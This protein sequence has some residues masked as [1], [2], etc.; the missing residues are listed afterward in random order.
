MGSQ[1]ARI[2]VA[3]GAL[4]A[5]GACLT[6]PVVR[7]EPT[8]KTGFAAVVRA[9]AV[10]KV[11]LL[12]MIDN[13]ASMGDKQEYLRAAV[14]D[15]LTRLV[16]PNCVDEADP[17]KV[18]GVSQNH[19][20]CPSG[21]KIEFPPVHDMHIAVVTSSLGPR[22]GD[23]CD[24]AIQGA[25][26][27]SLHNDDQGHLINRVQDGDAPIPTM[28]PSH[29]LA[30]FSKVDS[31]NGK[32]P[33]PGAAPIDDVAQLQRDFQDL[34]AGVGQRGCGVESQLESWYRFLIQPDPYESLATTPDGHATWV[35]V[36]ATILKQRHDFL[37]PDSLVAVVVLTDENDS[38]IDVRANNGS[39]FKFL[40]GA[41]APPRG[42]SPCDVNPGDP[43]CTSCAFV[44]P[45][46][47]ASDPNCQKGPYTAGNDWG[48]NLNLRHVHPK[49]KY[50]VDPQ[51]PIER[52]VDGLT[53]PM[54]PDRVGEYPPK[55]SHYVGTANCQNP[56]F[57]ARL[58]DGSDLRPETLCHLPPGPRTK[59]LIFYAHI[60]GVPSHLLHFDPADPDKSRLTDDDW[61]TILGK[62]PKAFDYTGID[63]HMIESF[64]PRP[65]V[66]HPETEAGNGTD[67]VHGR[68]WITNAAPDSVDR[69]FACT[70]DRVDLATGQPRELDCS[71]DAGTDV[72][73]CPAKAG[74]PSGQI[75]PLC[76]PDDVTKQI[77]AK[78]YPT[79]RELL[80]A[81]S[82]GTQGI[83]SSMCPIHVRE[84]TPGDPLF[85]YRPA[86]TAIVNRLKDALTNECL[87]RKLTVSAAQVPCLILETLPKPGDQRACDDSARGLRQPDPAILKRFREAKSEE[88][89]ATGGPSSGIPDPSTF[90]VCEVA[91]LP[92]GKD[93]STSSDAGWC[94]YE[95]GDC[96]QQIRFSKAGNPV[97]N[98][99]VDL[100]CVE[101]QGTGSLAEAGP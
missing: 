34:V 15:L 85:G 73:D 69:Q 47:G 12:F 11:D 82:L 58:P 100:Q 96:A 98:A 60:G 20:Q 22:L 18:I 4:V 78:A 26:G 24:P 79:I 39:A 64:A 46:T 93:C 23:H 29:F 76:K 77:K 81:R 33:S 42:T 67:P 28:N 13:S 17:N 6:R 68:E 48:F 74:A 80:L 9:A 41:F 37:R 84:E 50:G 89:R 99:V 44:D 55:S 10:D 25:N 45:A 62:D 87:P 16:A 71:Q 40:N 1:C 38:E 97:S 5:G 70:F 90:P 14:P 8:T 95:G 83:V 66:G 63:P 88:W 7:D 35:G 49:A 43:K 86:V 31:N 101:Q 53:S 65:A 94:Y 56:L 61:T 54:V 21:S 92:A 2:V 57:A 51:F 75:P 59:D 3:C 19:G 72:C 52:Y 91:Q 32:S 36:D 30:W 27:L